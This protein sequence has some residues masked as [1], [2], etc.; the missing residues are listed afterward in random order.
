MNPAFQIPKTE[1]EPEVTLVD[2]HYYC[3]AAEQG[4]L[5]IG[6]SNRSHL[7]D[8]ATLNEY[9]FEVSKEVWLATKE[10]LHYRDGDTAVIAPPQPDMYSQF[11]DET[12][13]WVDLREQTQ[14]QKDVAHWIRGIRQPR[15]VESDWTHLVDSPLADSGKQGE[16]ARYR[17]SLRDLPATFA[18]TEDFLEVVW[19]IQP[20]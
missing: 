5:I 8:P 7:Q 17:Q 3:K 6:W 11:D 16:W 19:P 14:K 15:L 2:R 18:T 20:E 13:E 10:Q 12:K 4:S 9:T 1:E